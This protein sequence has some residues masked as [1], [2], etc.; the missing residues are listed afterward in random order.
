MR[1]YILTEHEREIMRQ[2]I[3]GEKPYTYQMIKSRVKK[4]K[5]T[6]EGDMELIEKFLEKA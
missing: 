4:A 6:L 1:E 3:D 5:P 2:V